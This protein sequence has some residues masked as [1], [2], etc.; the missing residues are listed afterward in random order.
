MYRNAFAILAVF[1]LAGNLSTV[2]AAQQQA[3][4]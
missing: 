2:A 3:P 1:L 4:V